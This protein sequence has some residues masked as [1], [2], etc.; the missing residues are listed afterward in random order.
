MELIGN[1]A[2]VTGG[3]KGIGYG[4]AD[5]HAPRRGRRD[6][7]RNEGEITAAAQAV[8]AAHAGRRAIG[9]VATASSAE[10]FE[11][12]YELTEREL[13]P[14]GSWSITRATAPSARS[15]TCSKTTGTF[16]STRTSPTPLLIRSAS[17][18]CSTTTSAHR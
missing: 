18:P 2:I 11:R 9:V 14:V 7:A 10:D 17:G 13:G 6:H 1:V 16:S 5:P 12:V 4:V 15:S 3:S 8:T